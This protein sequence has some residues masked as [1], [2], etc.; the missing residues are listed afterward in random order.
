MPQLISRMTFA[1][2]VLL[3]PTVGVAQQ[4]KAYVRQAIDSRAE[5]YRDVALQIWDF[6]ELGAEDYRSNRCL[7]GF[8]GSPFL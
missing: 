5:V 7:T 4:G 8:Y 2:V 6:A 1:L 3:F